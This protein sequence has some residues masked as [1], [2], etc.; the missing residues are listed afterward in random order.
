MLDV[1]TGTGALAVEAIRA[2]AREVTAVDISRAAGL[3]ARFNTRVR[4]LPVRVEHGDVLDRGRGRR[5]DM[6][7][8]N[9]PY[10]PSHRPALPTRGRARAWDAGLGGRALLDPL[11]RSASRLLHPGGSLLMVH[12]ALC[13]VDETLEELAQ[14]GMSAT[15]QARRS[16]PF[17]PV[18]R[19]RVAYLSRA[20]LVGA[21]QDHEDL[22]VIRGERR[23]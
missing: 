8:A 11:C 4:R 14:H 23:D 9:P 2:G 5:F 13:G 15:V 6:I 12:S 19:G 21:S 17:G 3:A 7:L 16:V 1:G 10:V 18:M 20:G 22:V